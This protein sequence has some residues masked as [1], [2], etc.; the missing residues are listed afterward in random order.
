MS[1]PKHDELFEDAVKLV[2]STK[3]VGAGLI[4]RQFRIPY[5]RAAV[6]VAQMEEAGIVSPADKKSGKREVIESKPKGESMAPVAGKAAEGGFRDRLV[7]E[8]KDQGV[9]VEGQTGAEAEQRELLKKEVP[10][11]PMV[12]GERYMVRYLGTGNFERGSEDEP[13]VELEFS[14]AITDD[15]DELLDSQILNAVRYL[16]KNH[17]GLVG[18]IEIPDQT[19][20]LSLAP[21]MDPI[22][23]IAGVPVR[24]VAVSYVVSKGEGREKKT[25]RLVFRLLAD[26]DEKIK[27]F[28]GDHFEHQCWISMGPAQRSLKENAA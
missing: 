19:V 11:V 14:A 4:Q 18:K 5:S 16:R 2:Q 7:K 12:Q 8:A 13:K 22:I 9:P 6:L 21:D 24:H 26:I 23:H 1:D 17:A 25:L 20:D 27:N 28:M 15:H 10:I 3:T